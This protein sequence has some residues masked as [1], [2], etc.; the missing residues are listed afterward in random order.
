[1]KIAFTPFLRLQLFSSQTSFFMEF[2][3]QEFYCTLEK[4]QNMAGSL[5]SAVTNH[6]QSTSMDCCNPRNVKG[7]KLTEVFDTLEK[8][9]SYAV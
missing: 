6:G 3:G 1:M 9:E 4:V 8:L 2:T 5:S 7:R